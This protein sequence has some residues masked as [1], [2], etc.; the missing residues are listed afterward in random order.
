[1][2]HPSSSSSRSTSEALLI[3]RDAYG[4]AGVVRV[5]LNRPDAFNALSEDLIE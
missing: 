2:N 4:L 1:M 3:E 5:T